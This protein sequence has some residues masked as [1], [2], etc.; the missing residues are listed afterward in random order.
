MTSSLRLPGRLGPLLLF[1]LLAAL[2]VGVEH[3]IVHRAEFGQYP[4]LPL[5]VAVDLLVVVPTLFYFSVARP[6]R[7]PLSSLVGVGGACLALASWL[8]PAPQLQS[9]RV[10]H[11]LPPLLEAVTLCLTAAKGRRLVRAYRAAYAHEPHFWPSVRAAVQSLGAVGQLLLTELNLLRYAG[12][13]WWATP[14][15]P[16][17]ATAFSGHRESGF[18]ALVATATLVLTVETACVHLLAQHWCP[19][20]A[21]WLL[22][23][24]IYGVVLLVAHLHA[25]RLRPA[26]LTPTELHLRIGFVWELAVPRTELVA[27]RILPEA[28]AAGSGVLNLAKLLFATPNLLLTFAEPVVVAGPYGMRRTARH[29]AVYLD[30][31]RQFIAAVGLSS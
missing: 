2:V 4:A 11:L 29:V 22:F 12:L 8:I 20:L 3:V 19:S 30:Q 10:L 28:P 16:T 27:A 9:L 23:L 18:A 25:V 31:P 17:H 6:Y 21:P 1:G 5:G 13:G 7:L 26:L 24:D 14:E 15:T